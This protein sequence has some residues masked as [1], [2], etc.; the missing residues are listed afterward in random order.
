MERELWKLIVWCL[1]RLPR[2][3]PRGAV[4]DNRAIVAVYLW[5]A[6]H[7]RPVSWA[8][9]RANWP[10]QAWRR[11]LPDQ[12]TMSRRMGA[13]EFARDLERLVGLAQRR[14]AHALPALAPFRATLAVDGKP[15]A[16]SSF[17]GDADAKRGWGAGRTQR[18]YKTHVLVGEHRGVLAWETMPMNVAESCVAAR[19]MR[20]AA[21]EGELP[22]GA[23]V[24]GD[25]SYDSNPL[26]RVTAACGATLVAPRRRPGTGLGTTVKHHGNRL[27][28]IE[29]FERGP[30]R[31]AKE[32]RRDRAVVERVLGA[33]CGG[34]GG[35]CGLPPWVRTL[36]RVRL[37]VS[38]KV[39]LYACRE[40][41]RRSVAA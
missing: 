21:R 24:L 36:A 19:L 7:D 30:K 3:C 25:A 22:R 4:Y 18:G 10:A 23:R 13:P 41:R 5:A 35:L 31:R 16:V 8:C 11:A 39:F 20:R 27:Q 9:E 38:A 15:L 29:L 37:W 34:T 17:S 14:G 1:R 33:M 2:R 12:S 40:R 32:V 26:H 6:L 28:C